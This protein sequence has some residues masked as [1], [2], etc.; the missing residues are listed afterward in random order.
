MRS[1]TG[2]LLLFATVSA[3]ATTGT[4][5]TTAPPPAADYVVVAP[6]AFEAGLRPLLAHR[7]DQGHSTRLLYTEGLAFAGPRPESRAAA[8]RTALLRALGPSAASL[9]YLLLIGDVPD[10]ESSGVQ[11]SSTIPTFYARK[12]R[13]GSR[14]QSTLATDHPYA[15]PAPGQTRPIAVGRVPARTAADVEAFVEKTLRYET[16]DTGGAWQRRLLLFAGP[17]DFG[18]LADTL[19]EHLST[20]LIDHA[21]PYAYDVHPVFAKAKSKFAYR[22]DRLGEKLL[23]EMSLGAF[24]V[25]YVGHGSRSHFDAVR[26]RGKYYPYGSIAQL[27]TLSIPQGAPFFVSLTC[28]TGQFDQ[29]HGRPSLAET[30]LLNPKKPIAV[31][32]S[33]R[34]S[35]PYPNLLYADALIEVFLKERV[36]T[37]GDGLLRTKELMMASGNPL[38]EMLLKENANELRAEHRDLYNLLGDPATRLRYARSLQ[39]SIEPAGPDRAS[40]RVVIRLPEDGGAH[41][42]RSDATLLVTLETMRSNPGVVIPRSALEKMPT[43]ALFKT[44]EE[45]HRVAADPVLRTWRPTMHNGEATVLLVDLPTHEPLLIKALLE[46]PRGSASGYVWIRSP[47]ALHEG[48]TGTK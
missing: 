45:N 14:P 20:R 47:L 2:L 31:F 28:S 3:C 12:L 39:L 10:P 15:A 35:H 4:H 30:L 25:T 32:A 16:Q 23:S 11:A 18:P 13:Y 48:I 6:R 38:L 34:V 7:Q 29:P 17:A 19:I 46:D 9:R 22:F 43:E 1:P 21:I 33:S 42:L 24:M 44:M 41:T 26:F 5:T 27:N 36:T 37:V 8:F 40:Q